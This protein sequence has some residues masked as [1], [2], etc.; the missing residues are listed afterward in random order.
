MRKSPTECR[1]GERTGR[2]SGVLCGSGKTSTGVQGRDMGID[3]GTGKEIGG[4]RN[5]TAVMDVQSYQ[6]G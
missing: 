1:S 2:V 6:A 4:R 5:A 3:E